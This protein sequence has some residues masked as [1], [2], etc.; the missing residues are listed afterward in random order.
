VVTA[1][2]ANPDR[3]TSRRSQ[4]IHKYYF[5]IARPLDRRCPKQTRYYNLYVPI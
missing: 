4:I 5:A 2:V 3:I 1:V